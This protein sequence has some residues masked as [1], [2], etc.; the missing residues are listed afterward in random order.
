MAQVGTTRYKVTDGTTTK[1]VT[2]AQS[3]TQ[4]TALTAGTGPDAALRPTLGTIEITPHGGSV[5]NVKK[6]TSAQAITVQGSFITWKLGVASNAAGKGTIAV[7]ANAAPT[8]ANPIPDQVATVAG[9][10]SYVIP[11]N[12][13]ADLNEDTLTYT[14]TLVG[15][16]ALSTVA[17]A[18][19]AT[20]RTVSKAAGASTV[21]TKAIRVTASDG[22]ASIFDDFNVVVS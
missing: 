13:F 4:V 16:A 9:A 6:L 3:T 22:T 12:T 11:A 15:G 2:L 14:A 18:F 1:I 20:T 7:V 10:F 19:D 17:F 5:E 21:G 8:V